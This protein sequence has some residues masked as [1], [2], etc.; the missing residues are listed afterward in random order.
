[1]SDSLPYALLIAL[2]PFAGL[3]GK[4]PPG[5]LGPVIAD[6]LPEGVTAE[7]AIALAVEHI[8]PARD[9]LEAETLTELRRMAKEDYGKSGQSRAKKEDLIP[10]ILKWSLEADQTG[11]VEPPA[12]PA[13]P[14]AAPETLAAA[15]APPKPPEAPMAT[16]KHPPAS[17]VK[18]IRVKVPLT[19]PVTGRGGKSVGAKIGKSIFRGELATKIYSYALVLDG[20]ESGWLDK[21]VQVVALHG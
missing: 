6:S 8:V 2:A 16:P 14:A 1:M 12:E 3:F 10:K 9:G 7:D 18:E 11:A 4:L 21:H 5:E 20:R 15:A 17:S 13:A 19:L